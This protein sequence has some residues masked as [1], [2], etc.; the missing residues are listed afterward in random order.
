MQDGYLYMAIAAVVIFFITAG[1]VIAI[2]WIAMPFSIFGAKELL[3][4]VLEEQ[5]KTNRLLTALLEEARQRES[6]KEAEKP[7]DVTKP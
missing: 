4:R 6:A 2:L 7:V 1:G 5:E 3:K